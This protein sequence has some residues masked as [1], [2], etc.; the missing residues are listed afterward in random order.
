VT[1]AVIALDHRVQDQISTRRIRVVKYRGSLHGTNEYPF[2]IDDT[3]ITVVPI[4]SAILRH[5]VSNERLT[6]GIAKLDEMLGGEGY[7]RGSTILVSGTAG[8]G[9]TSICAHLAESTCRRGERCLF[10]SYEE[11]P[12]QLERNMASIGLSLRE[13]TKRGLLRIESLRATAHGL[14]GHLGLIHTVTRQFEP[15]VVVIDP[16]GTFGGGGELHD[17]HLLAVRVID[18]LKSRGVTVLMSNLAHGGT[19][20][21]A[22]NMA[23]SS[24]VDTWLLVQVLEGNG[25]RNRALYVLKSRG[26]DHSNQVREFLM[27]SSGIDLVEPYVGAEGVLTGTARLAR[28]ESERNRKHGA[29][30][31][32]ER[33]QRLLAQK[34]SVLERSIAALNAEFAAE[35][36]EIERA[37]SDARTDQ[38][39][40]EA[41]RDLMGKLRGGERERR[42]VSKSNGA[43]KRQKSAPRPASRQ[44]D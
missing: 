37:I 31:D 40:V 14:E 18:F 39:A 24:L 21:E 44:E 1:D 15:T 17:S 7:Y 22:T 34:R 9:K 11:S 43:H 16:I 23:L 33:N 41:A 4:T 13:W 35:A 5:A 42:P 19:S 10:I 28:E 12:A 6:T 32:I 36:F 26:M 30:R 25:E 8:S 38:S 29:A 20:I 27:T 2:L 3:G